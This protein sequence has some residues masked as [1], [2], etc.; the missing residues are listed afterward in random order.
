VYEAIAK[1]AEII[2]HARCPLPLPEKPSSSRFNLH[3][4]EIDQVRLSLQR[5]RRSLH[6]PLRLDIYYEHGDRRELLERWCLEYTPSESVYFASECINTDPIVQL[7]HVCK[8]IVIWLRTLYSMSRL[9]PAHRLYASHKLS[10]DVNVLE[11]W[12][13]VPQ[14]KSEALPQ[15]LTPH[16]PL[17]YKV[18]YAP[19]V[20][21]F[22]PSKKTQPIPMKT[23]PNY[24]A[25]PSTQNMTARSAPVQNDFD[26][27]VQRTQQR[28]HQ[29]GMISSSVNPKAPPRRLHSDMEEVSNTSDRPL[30]QR[31]NS[32][33]HSTQRP[34]ALS[35]ALLADESS[36]KRRAAL[37]HPP[38]I[39]SSYGYA[40]N[41]GPPTLST[42]SSEAKL[43]SS[44]SRSPALGS[45]PPAFAVGSH[46]APPPFFLGSY[47][48]TTLIPPRQQQQQLFQQ[49]HQTPPFAA[50]PTA[51]SEPDFAAV[52][53]G[54]P[55]SLDLLHSSP[56]KPAGN[57][58]FSESDILKHSTVVIPPAAEEEEDMPF[59][60]EDDVLL[61]DSAVTLLAH[62]CATASRLQLFESAVENEEDMLMSS[63]ADQ[64]AEFKSF[65]ASLHLTPPPPSSTNSHSKTSQD[66]SGT[67]STLISMRT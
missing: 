28:Q 51:L 66:G 30:L 37:H 54:E 19:D 40:Y 43:S 8:K 1:A 29:A 56:F 53:D 58:S 34:S 49:Q 21:R 67:S 38:P 27:M 60:V 26:A 45:T 12:Q 5:W 20:R 13:D 47:N 24:I 63:L 7:R 14:F 52:T 4:P 42:P 46:N 57:T 16:G 36:E 11:E 33:E 48:N 65:G 39:E 22:L 31:S 23:R 62:K 15:V 3:V 6:V 9:L 41:T 55:S 10:F 35:L 17:Q 44:P 2:V 25:I 32:L 59:A 61:E 64:L 18:W 50:M